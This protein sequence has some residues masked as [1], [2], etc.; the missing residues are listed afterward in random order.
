MVQDIINNEMLTH[1]NKYHVLGDASEVGDGRG[2]TFTGTNAKC[3]SK[4]SRTIN[5]AKSTQGKKISKSQ[6]KHTRGRKIKKEEE[7][8]TGENNCTTKLLQCFS[9]NY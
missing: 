4:L 5:I 3:E 6:V 9:S 2:V 1:S 7:S 8:R